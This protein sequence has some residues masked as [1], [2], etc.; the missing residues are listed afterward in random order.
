MSKKRILYSIPNFDTAGSG[1][2]ML[3]IATRLNPDFFEP[4]IVCQHDKGAFFQKVKDSGIPTHIIEYVSPSR[5]FSQLFSKSWQVAKKFKSIQPDLIHSYHYSSDYTEGLAAQLARIP[6]AFTKKNMSWGGKSANAWKLRSMLAK[7]IAVQN[8]DMMRDFYP[9]SKK[10]FYLPRGVDNQKFTS[11]APNSIIREAMQS[12]TEKRVIIC[13]ANMVPVKGIELLIKA[14]QALHEF[15][16]DWELW[17]VGDIKNDYGQS[18]VQLV[19][20]NSMQ[21]HVKFSGKVNN[22]NEYLDQAEIFVL[23]TKDE[24]RREGSPVS[25]LEAMANGKVVIGS[26]VPGIKDQ[27]KTF[28]NHIFKAGSSKH[29]K[30]SIL[31]F[32]QQSVQKNEEL[33]KQFQQL[34]ESEFRIDQEVKRHEELYKKILKL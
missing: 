18:L 15:H 9:N 4:H 6:W 25:L 21:N 10:T 3:N 22:V 19:E 16:N 1:K 29:L 23:P 20:A 32:M 34:A 17:L 33:G 28:P 27:L 5:P 11:Q 31:P 13:V 8:T 14:Y 2:A 26:S 24:G 30:E 7:R 12:S